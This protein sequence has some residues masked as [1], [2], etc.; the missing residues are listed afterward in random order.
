MLDKCSASAFSSHMI[1]QN[2]FTSAYLERP[3]P[4]KP[5]NLAFLVQF[6]LLILRFAF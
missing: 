1:D 4:T 6:A 5:N 2:N 3:L